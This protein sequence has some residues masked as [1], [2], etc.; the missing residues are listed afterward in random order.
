MILY[1]IEMIYFFLI[2]CGKLLHSLPNTMR[3][4]VYSIKG[5]EVKYK[6]TKPAG[7]YD[8]INFKELEASEKVQSFEYIK[9]SQI[10]HEKQS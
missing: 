10:N 6:A 8:Y 2:V 5:K 7:F 3:S 9:S 1:C 4:F